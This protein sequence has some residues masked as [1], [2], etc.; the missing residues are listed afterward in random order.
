[1]PWYHSLEKTMYI[2]SVN[3]VN[4]IMLT[5]I[6]FNVLWM[7]KGLT[8]IYVNDFHF[9]R[10]FIFKNFRNAKRFFIVSFLS[11]SVEIADITQL[12]CKG[13]ITEALRSTLISLT[14]FPSSIATLTSSA[15]HLENEA[16][17]ICL[18]SPL[19]PT[20]RGCSSPVQLA[21]TYTW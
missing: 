21:G 7:C 14:D 8:N 6:T 20:S 19:T 12:A 10:I 2:Y 11:D 3:T 17:I 15:Y 1:M 9:S 5:T 18:K 16:F 13:F 4:P